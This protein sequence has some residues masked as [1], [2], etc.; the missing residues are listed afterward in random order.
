MRC[1]HQLDRGLEVGASKLGMERN[2]EVVEPVL[3]MTIVSTTH[4]ATSIGDGI[5]GATRLKGTDQLYGGGW[6]CI[7]L[8]WLECSVPGT[9]EG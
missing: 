8:K 9:E 4:D 2:L 6:I 7:G 1:E 3:M 5:N